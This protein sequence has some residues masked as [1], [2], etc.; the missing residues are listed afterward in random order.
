MKARDQHDHDLDL[1]PRIDPTGHRTAEAELFLGSSRAIPICAREFAR[2]SDG[3]AKRLESVADAHPGATAEVRRTPGRCI[4]QLGPVALTV[5]WVR[6]RV[7]SVAAGRLLVAEWRGTVASATPRLP[8]TAGRAAAVSAAT[9]VRE[10]VLLADAT[11]EM[12]WRWRPESR[13]KH[14]GYASPDLATRCV[15]SLIGAL[16]KAS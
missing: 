15:D 7:D 12:D 6:D 13:R 4:V 3:I 2:L 14:E 10:Q 1:D 8:E 11:G 16:R 5:S 9:L